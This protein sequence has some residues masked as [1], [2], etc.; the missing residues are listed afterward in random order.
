M[1][2]YIVVCLLLFLTGCNTLGTTN[3]EL[4]PIVTQDGKVVCC[5]ATVFNG[6]D[7]DQLKFK[8]KIDANGNVEAVLDETGVNSSDPATVGAQNN[9]KMLELM[10]KLIPVSN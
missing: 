9:A 6:K 2:K 1:I 4:E 3:Y 8:L 7:Y 10:N 5:K